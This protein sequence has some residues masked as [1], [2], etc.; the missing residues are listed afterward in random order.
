[1]AAYGVCIDIG[2]MPIL[3]H[4]DSAEF[5][6]LLEDRYG[7]FVVGAGPSA[8]AS[9]KGP[10]LGGHQG[11]PCRPR[12]AQEPRRVFELEVELVPPGIVSDA[13][14]ARVRLEGRRWVMERSDFR[15]EWDLERRQGCVRQSPNPYSIDSVLRILH[16]LVLAREGGFLVHAAS[17]IRNGR[18]FLF[19]GASG[20]GKTTIARLAPPDV[21]LLTDEISYVRPWKQGIRNRC[22]VPGA[23]CQ[24]AGH[25]E[26]VNAI[27]EADIANG[28]QETGDWGSGT[29]DSPFHATRNPKP[30]SSSL[31]PDTWN[32]APAYEAFGTPFTGE[33]ARIGEN[34]RAPVAALYLLTQGAGNR[35][36]AVS[37][38]EAVRALLQ[39]ILFFAQDEELVRLVFQS[40]FDFVSRVPVRRLVFAQ[41]ARVWEL[42]G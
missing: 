1:M 25:S 23:R 26:Q 17:A 34:L 6:H 42:I 20:A 16:S 8:D 21:V 38:A 37:H 2:E 33:L 39:N 11:G 13:E 3:V 19:A 28:E 32:L 24:V 18:A 12:R 29:R 36:E 7:S 15:A 10:A 30:G 40:A 14:E 41:D 4:T 27:R 35:I 31:T 9:G 22:Q 5:A